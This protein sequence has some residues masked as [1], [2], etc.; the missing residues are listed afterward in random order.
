MGYTNSPPSEMAAIHIPAPISKVVREKRIISGHPIKVT[1]TRLGVSL[2]VIDGT[3]DQT[4]DSW[5]LSDDKAQFATETAAPNDGFGATFIYGHNIP[6]VFEPLKDLVVGDI[7][8][9]ETDNGYTFTYRYLSDEIVSPEDTSVLDEHSVA[10][11]VTLMTCDG[12]WSEN[13][14]VM[15]FELQGV[16]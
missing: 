12:I 14:R 9:V 16:A 7:L 11:R 15:Y 3:Y 6:T 2:P 13:R 10:P 5:T 1:V 4:G 8:T